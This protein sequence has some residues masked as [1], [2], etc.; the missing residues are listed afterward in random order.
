[1]PI[2]HKGEPDEPSVFVGAQAKLKL[3]GQGD[4]GQPVKWWS[5]D[6]PTLGTQQSLS[7]IAPLLSGLINLA[8]K[9]E[10]EALHLDFA[11]LRPIAFGACVH[12]LQV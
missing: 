4:V 1:M 11:D 12:V 10:S 3:S 2:L 9:S 8:E 7:W 5:K 6:S